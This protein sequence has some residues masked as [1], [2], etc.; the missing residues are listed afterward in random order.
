MAGWNIEVILSDWLHI[1]DLTLTPECAASALLELTETDSIW[2]GANQDERLR[3]A[4][5]EFVAEC[6]RR[7]IRNR[8]QVFAV[9][10]MLPARG[11][12][13]PTLA[14]KH[15]NGAEAVVMARWLQ[16]IC[17]G[18][19]AA[20]PDSE[21]AQLGAA[22]FVNLVLMRKAMS[23]VGILMPDEN[24]RQ[25]RSA[26]YLFHASLNSLAHS[27]VQSGN[28]RWKI[29][30]KLH[31]LDHLVLDQSERVCPMAVSTYMDEDMVG[32]VKRFAMMSHPN[33]LGRQVLLRY[34]A[35]CCTR[36]QRRL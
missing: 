12:A 11:A 8:G 16:G 29:R 18:I 14:Q 5:C 27:A 21:H 34:S 32:K 10:H 24:L 13:Y 9:K 6:K 17:L 36:W 28:I 7:K 31:K 33:L 3:R 1:V 19:A 20:S 22:V 35:Y 2:Q 4:Y 15:L 25:L 26:N 30:P 23:G